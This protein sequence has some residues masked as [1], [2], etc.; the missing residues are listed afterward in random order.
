VYAQCCLLDGG[1]LLLFSACS[2]M[3][4]EA[5]TGIT[6]FLP[7]CLPCLY[8]DQ[9]VV[10]FQTTVIA[11]FIISKCVNK[12]TKGNGNCNA[13]AEWQVL[14]QALYRVVHLFLILKIGRAQIAFIMSFALIKS[15]NQ[16]KPIYS[17]AKVQSSP[18]AKERSKA[19][20]THQLLLNGRKH[21]TRWRL[22]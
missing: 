3:D 14:L 11:C 10:S 7:A 9:Q 2:S 4:S 18:R 12:E 6:R 16:I 22:N 8:T 19:Y 21:I 17:P 15:S 20:P 1:L 13:F 5:S